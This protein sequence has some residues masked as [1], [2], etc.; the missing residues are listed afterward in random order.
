MLLILGRVWIAVDIVEYNKFIAAYHIFDHDYLGSQVF[1]DEEYLTESDDEDNKREAEEKPCPFKV[2]FT[3]YESQNY[4]Q[5][6]HNIGQQVDLVP[7]LSQPIRNLW[8]Q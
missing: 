5:N 8:A 1:H 2:G 3:Q 4:C 7:S 6:E